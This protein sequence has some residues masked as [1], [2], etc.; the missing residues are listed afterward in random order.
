MRPAAT[1]DVSSAR[2]P[3]RELSAFLFDLDGV[4][5][6]TAAVHGRAWKRLFDDFLASREGDPEQV[7]PFRLPDDYIAY[8]DGKP[9]YEGVRSFLESRGIDLR[10]GNADDPPDALTICGLGNRKNEIFHEVLDEQGVEVLG[11]TV[12]LIRALRARGIKVACVSSSKNGQS[13]LERAGLLELFDAVL[14]G[15][16]LERHRLRGKPRPDSFLHAAALLDVGP[17][18]AAVVEDAVAGVAAGRAGGFGLVI[19]MDRGAGRQALLDGGADI[20]VKDL[21]E[22]ARL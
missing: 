11:G 10:W 13:V 9:R 4:V 1:H 6:D 12:G 2:R 18:E 16:E 8:V 19:G 5:T 3:G 22:Y 14:D 21:G 17:G 15:N 7:Q 20:V